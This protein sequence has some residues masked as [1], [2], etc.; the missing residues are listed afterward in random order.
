[1]DPSGEGGE[2]KGTLAVNTDITEFRVVFDV[3][4]LALEDIQLAMNR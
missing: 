1:M 3:G 4:S 2:G